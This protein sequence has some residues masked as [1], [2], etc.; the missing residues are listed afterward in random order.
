M[1]PLESVKEALANEPPAPR[2]VSTPPP[3]VRPVPRSTKPEDKST[4]QAR[5]E[6]EP[7]PSPVSVIRPAA[8]DESN[9]QP[10]IV[11]VEKGRLRVL[12][13]NL[14]ASTLALL[15]DARTLAKQSRGVLAMAALRANYEA[16]VAEHSPQGDTGGVDFFGAPYR[17]KQRR[18]LVAP[19]NVQL[20]VAEREASGVAQACT[21]L[22]ISASD[23][24]SR[25]IE[26]GYGP[27]PA[28]L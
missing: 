2:R 17:P 13:V 4:R 8:T 28:S 10:A 27:S 12:Q 5:R 16:I 9:E 24:F 25:A 26:R 22:G 19:R 3:S 20:Y 14:P 11:G 23:L 7:A 18:G 21:V 15:D 6:A 1:N